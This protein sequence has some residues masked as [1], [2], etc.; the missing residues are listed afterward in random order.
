[1][2]L[3]EES[4]GKM[5]DYINCIE[6][7]PIFCFAVKPDNTIYAVSNMADEWGYRKGDELPALLISKLKEGKTLSTSL[8]SNTLSMTGVFHHELL[9]VI[10][11]E[12]T[13]WSKQIERL[14]ED[15]ITQQETIDKFLRHEISMPMATITYFLQKFLTSG[16]VEL[17]HNAI[18]AI[19]RI[20]EMT[21]KS[22]Y[23]Y[24]GG[25]LDKKN[26]VAKELIEEAINDLQ[27]V[28]H[29]SKAEIK[30]IGNGTIIYGDKNRIR[31]AFMNLFEN[32]IKYQPEKQIPKINIEIAQYSQGT[33]I[34]IS[35]NG[36]G[37]PKQHWKTIFRPW[38]R[39]HKKSETKYPGSGIG[40]SI[41]WEVLKQHQGEVSV[42]S[43]VGKGS[44]FTL[45]F[46]N[47]QQK[48]TPSRR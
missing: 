33:S 39:L 9:T 20:V 16:K 17:I 14:Q 7:S 31:Q 32:A 4:F 35:D 21:A 22:A 29:E 13:E 11:I 18:A 10:G 43:T 37:I 41:V 42:E 15:L 36:I 44:N 47:E 27:S 12:V 28:I 3:L 8:G 1:M 45:H 23:L 46:P 6:E 38:Q 34:S 48:F 2:K 19:K 40:L 26:F 30:V 25:H 5:T 24:T